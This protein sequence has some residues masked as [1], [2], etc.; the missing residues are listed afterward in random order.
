MPSAVAFWRVAPSVRFSALAICEA[1]SLRAIVLSVLTSSD[2][3]GR[4]EDCDFGALATL[5]P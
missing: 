3:Q 2:P 5:S 4:L 1:G